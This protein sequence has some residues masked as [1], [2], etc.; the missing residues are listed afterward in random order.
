MTNV[1]KHLWKTGKKAA[2]SK[3]LINFMIVD[4]SNQLLRFTTAGS[5]DDGKST[6]IGRLLLDSKSIFVD[7][8]EAVK[9]SSV[10]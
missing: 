10:K 1:L 2:T 6:V 4:A 3:I 8:L 9:Y 7:Q 5:V